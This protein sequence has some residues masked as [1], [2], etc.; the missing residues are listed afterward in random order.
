MLVGSIYHRDPRIDGSYVFVMST[1]FSNDRTSNYRP[2]RFPPSHIVS[3]CLS[4][5]NTTNCWLAKYL[6]LIHSSTV[7]TQN[8]LIIFPT[9]KTLDRAHCRHLLLKHCAPCTLHYVVVPFKLY[10]TVPPVFDAKH[11]VSVGF[12][13]LLLLH[14]LDLFQQFRCIS[15]L[16]KSFR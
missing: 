2:S 12:I 5:I 16:S 13:N 3:E 15:N 9:Q 8:S 4:T 11:C 6:G 14:N 10:S 7:D 1:K